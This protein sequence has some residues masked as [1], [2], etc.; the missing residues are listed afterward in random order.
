[1]CA[2]DEKMPHNL[3]EVSYFMKKKIIKIK[4]GKNVKID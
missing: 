2:A 1:M 4:I 3:L